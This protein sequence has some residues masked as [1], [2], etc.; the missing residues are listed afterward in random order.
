MMKW[1]RR[2]LPLEYVTSIILLYLL[3]KMDFVVIAART[4]HESIDNRVKLALLFIHLIMLLAIFAPLISRYLSQGGDERL[5]RFIALPEVTKNI[6]YI[7][8]Y[9]FLSGLALSAFYLSILLFTIKGVY[10]LAGWV[11]SGIYVFLMFVSSISIASLSLMRFIWLF[12][13]YN[14]YVYAFIALAASSMCM[15]VISIAM[16]MASQ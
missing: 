15:A 4:S 11:L 9:D 14:R 13:K 10:E 6:T 8:F 16:Q 3:V 5:T 12:T 7:D 1:I 2:K